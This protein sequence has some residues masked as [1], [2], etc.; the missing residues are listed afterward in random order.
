MNV[1][2]IL[3][4]VVLIG[5]QLFILL[6]THKKS[7]VLASVF[8]TTTE[9]YKVEKYYIPKKELSSTTYDIILSDKRRYK[10]KGDDVET[11]EDVVFTEAGDV[12]GLPGVPSIEKKTRIICKAKDKEEVSLISLPGENPLQ[13][14]INRVLNNYLIR[15]KGAASDY[16][17]IKDVVER[18][19]NS[20][21][22]EIETQTP[23]PLYFGLMGTMLGIIVGIGDI[24]INVGFDQFVEKPEEHIGG[25]MGDVAMAMIV[26]CCGILFTTTLSFFAKKAK[27]ILETRKNAFYSWFQ[28]ELMPIISKENAST[29]LKRLEENLSKFNESFEDNVKELNATF[30]VVKETSGNQAL[31]M[32]TLNK[33]DLKKMAEANIEILSRFNQTVGQLEKF[34]S[35][36]NYS[37][38]VLDDIAQRN[39]AISEATISVDSNLDKALN[40]LKNGVEQQMSVLRDSLRKSEEEME[41]LVACESRLFA[42]QDSKINAFF[43]SIQSFKPLIEGIN[44]WKKDLKSQ[45]ME[46]SRLVDAISQMPLHDG[47]GGVVIKEKK[48]LNPV[49][50]SIVAAVV[51]LLLGGNMYYSWKMT[52][53]IKGLVGVQAP[54]QADTDTLMQEVAPTP[55]SDTVVAATEKKVPAVM[56]KTKEQLKTQA[57]TKK[58]SQKTEV[59]HNN[60]RSSLAY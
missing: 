53:A 18:N 35:Y 42:N 3:I 41:K 26:S 43:D 22:E 55:V 30:S 11:Y 2:I 34:N 25:L 27:S 48:T 1:V 45:T 16:G 20:L 24:A 23:W 6:K 37:Q 21:E 28:S 51:V 14:E 4:I 38:T 36:I 46:I 59:R 57:Q 58:S 19:C 7:K 54:Q 50:I 47:D 32:K 39:T 10:R 12:D 9:G 56:S 8:E 15:N 49:L 33:M 5:L 31:L 40:E 44:S 29:G 17:L 52:N 13:K 60:K